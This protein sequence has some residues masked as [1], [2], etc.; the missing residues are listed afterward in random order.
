MNDFGGLRDMGNKIICT[1]CGGYGKPGG[2][3]KCGK[4]S[5]P[6]I[7]LSKQKLPE[8]FI[9]SCRWNLIPDEYIGIDWGKGYLLS[10][11]EE[12]ENDVNF[13]LFLDQCEKFH[14]IF[15]NGKRVNKSFFLC[16]PPEFG[17]DTLAFSCMQYAKKNGFTV[18]PF[19]DTT[20]VKRLLILGGE[21]PEYKVLNRVNFD[22]YVTSEVVFVSV[23]KTQYVKEAYIT[24][25]ELLSKR[26]RLGLPTYIMSEY[27]LDVLTKDTPNKF[28]VN[29]FKKATVR[30]NEMKNPA[31]VEFIPR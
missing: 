16:A 31:V 28:N 24:I 14:E 15:K 5:N 22:D 12:Y 8:K 23:T 29:K 17:K 19:L 2:C 6:S 9:D 30:V 18:A 4:D 7:E 3:D 10:S 25:L 26:S 11:Y 13:K 20:D 27:P 21:R 1:M